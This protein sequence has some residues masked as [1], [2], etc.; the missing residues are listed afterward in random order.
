MDM[1]AQHNIFHGIHVGKQFNILKGSGDP[2]PGNLVGF[3]VFNTISL[4]PDMA[5]IGL[6]QTGNA[7]EKGGLSGTV[8]P[9]Q[10]KNLTLFHRKIYVLQCLY[11]AKGDRQICYSKKI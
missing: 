3:P 7:V 1:A 2:H 4:K 6:I 8:R 5:F 10:R 9:D 11:P